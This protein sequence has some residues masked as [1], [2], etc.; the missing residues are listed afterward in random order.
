MIRIF[1]ILAEFSVR[2]F[3]SYKIVKFLKVSIRYMQT[4]NS[5]GRNY[6][7]SRVLFHTS[8]RNISCYLNN[9]YSH[10]NNSPS[11][12]FRS[13][14]AHVLSAT[15]QQ[16]QRLGKSRKKNIKNIASP[17]QINT[18]IVLKTSV[19]VN[20]YQANRHF[21]IHLYANVHCFNIILH[22]KI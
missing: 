22:N 21:K 9:S 2:F 4:A 10:S 20:E 6:M 19:Q 15:F 18:P 17:A 11:A 1:Y 8:K 12:A 5:I 14:S 3:K 13:C 7:W 16:F